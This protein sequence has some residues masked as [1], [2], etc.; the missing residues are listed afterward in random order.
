[1]LKVLKFT[2]Q[3]FIK[4]PNKTSVVE[5]ETERTKIIGLKRTSGPDKLAL[6]SL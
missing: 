3:K 5:E 1:M 4:L 2:Q 6:P